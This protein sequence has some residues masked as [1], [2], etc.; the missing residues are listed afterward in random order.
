[1]EFLIDHCVERE[2]A[3]NNGRSSVVRLTH[4]QDKARSLLSSESVSQQHALFFFRT[5]AVMDGQA[6]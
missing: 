3:V 6:R 4:F 5:T 1:M 2:Q